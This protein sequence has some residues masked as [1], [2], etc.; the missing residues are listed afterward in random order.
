M[1]SYLACPWASRAVSW[2]LW[3]LA[4]LQVLHGEVQT[5]RAAAAALSESLA[6]AIERLNS[7]ETSLEVRDL[8]PNAVRVQGYEITCG[9]YGVWAPGSF[10][11]HRML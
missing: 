5:Q 11:S 2:G 8:T 7:S 3:T 4:E 1:R 10:A 9:G 6:K